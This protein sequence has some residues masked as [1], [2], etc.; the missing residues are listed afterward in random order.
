V[1]PSIGRAPTAGRDVDPFAED[2]TG[3]AA[4]AVAPV[5]GADGMPSEGEP[6]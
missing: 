3:E 6:A 2:D 5:T 4:S 1:V